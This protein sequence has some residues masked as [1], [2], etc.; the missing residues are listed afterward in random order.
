MSGALFVYYRVA[1]TAAARAESA[2]RRTIEDLSSEHCVRGR[3][4]KGR[5][6]PL[7]WMEVYEDVVDLSVFE[8]SLHR[9]AQAAGLDA[10]LEKGERRH[11]ECFIEC[12]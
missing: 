6:E 2:V 12:A 7:L 11:V 1:S 10:F 3:L 5:N 4:M 8:D 9:A